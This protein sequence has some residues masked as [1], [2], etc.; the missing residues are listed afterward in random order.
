MTAAPPVVK[1]ILEQL[2]RVKPSGDGW[3]AL[4]PAHLDQENSLSIGLG[5]DGRVLLNCFAGCA[6]EDIVR[7]VGLEMKALFPAEGGGGGPYPLRQK[8]NSA[9]VW[10]HL[11]AVRQGKSAA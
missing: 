3:S 1:R 6:V 4:C 11:G 5:D 8:R 2:K 7:A 10:L 9:R